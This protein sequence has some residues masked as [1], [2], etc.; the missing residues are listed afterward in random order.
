MKIHGTIKSVR[1]SSLPPFAA[2]FVDAGV[3]IQQEDLPSG[4]TCVK[5]EASALLR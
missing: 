3:W 2:D 5:V 4:E 1:D